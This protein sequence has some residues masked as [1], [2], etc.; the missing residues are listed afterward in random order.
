MGTLLLKSLLKPLGLIP[1]GLRMIRL[2]LFLIMLLMNFLR[3]RLI[4]VKPRIAIWL[5][6]WNPHLEIIIRALPILRCWFRGIS[7]PKPISYLFLT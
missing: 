2:M 4:A 6:N 1:L 3:G 7:M 5:V